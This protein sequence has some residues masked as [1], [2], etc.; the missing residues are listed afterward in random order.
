MTLLE[1]I[2]SFKDG[3]EAKAWIQANKGKLQEKK[4]YW[5]ALSLYGQKFLADKHTLKPEEHAYDVLNSPLPGTKGFKG[6]DLDGKN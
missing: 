2:N 4:A 3:N 1:M 6:G 5:H